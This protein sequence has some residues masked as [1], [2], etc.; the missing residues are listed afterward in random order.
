[1]SDGPRN[2]PRVI[3]LA[4]F[5]TL[6]AVAC[7]TPNQSTGA[8]DHAGT[9]GPGMK[10]WDLGTLKLPVAR[11]LELT[12]VDP[13]SFAAALG[14]DPVRT[15]EF[16]RDSIGFEAYAGLL[17]GPRGT[18]LAMAGNSADRAALLGAM[19]KAAGQ[20]VRYARGTLPEKDAT[21][22]VSSMWAVP[23]PASVDAAARQSANADAFVERLRTSVKRN[24]T[25]IDDALR[26]AGS[27]PA[28]PDTDLAAMTREARQHY[29]VQWL[30][31]GTWTDLDPSFADAS[32]GTTH[33]RVEE[34]T[35]ELPDAIHHQVTARIKVEESTDP[36]TSRTILTYNARA[37][38]LPG[39]HVVLIHI[40]ENWQGRAG[41]LAGA[42]RSAAEDTGRVKPAL[43]IGGQVL[44]GDAFS[45]RVKSGGTGGVFGQLSGL[46]TRHAAQVALREWLEVEFTAPSGSRETVVRDLFDVA[47]K[48]RRAAGPALTPA[49]IQARTQSAEALD[50]AAALYDLTFTAGRIDARHLPS[51]GGSPPSGQGRPPDLAAALQRI[52]IMFAAL[53]DALVHRVGEA[54]RRAVVFYPESP[55]LFICELSMDRGV[56]RA[57]LDLRRSHVRAAGI[58]LQPGDLVAARIFRGVVEGTLERA[59]VEYVTARARQEGS[60]GPVMSTT[61][62]FEE[63]ERAGVAA[64]L[65]PRQESQLDRAIAADARARVREET[66]HGFLALAPQRALAIGGIPRFG[67]WRVDAR[68]G[69]T[70]AVTDEGL[71]QAGTS[72]QVQ[73]DESKGQT[74]V[75]VRD[76]LGR[77][78]SRGVYSHESGVLMGEEDLAQDLMTL[79]QNGS[80]WEGTVRLG[81]SAMW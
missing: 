43:L 63:A 42:M 59:I 20:Q 40:P 67:W 6:T 53:S 28:S 75:V 51:A 4:T 71:Y 62:V 58:G 16:V 29:W 8:P 38:D 3:A 48:A 55:R 50:V 79:M 56:G 13:A 31:N 18:L 35:T 80:R 14:N 11:T 78:V 45:Q 65:L 54:G 1:M 76:Y 68:S 70:V 9:R 23:Q 10:P 77:T 72:Y 69:E 64:V 47:G 44:V 27:T 81:S 74:T 41:G 17:R 19:L 2:L 34:T 60:A 61:A 33:A 22:V 24:Y 15:F 30:R 57:I 12:H 26:A 49:E 46:G 36:P 21:D 37:A 66:S 5:V 7:G 32:V 25:L 73:V 39:R 52:N